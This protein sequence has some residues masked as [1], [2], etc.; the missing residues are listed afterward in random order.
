VFLLDMVPDD[1]VA[2]GESANDI[3]MPTLVPS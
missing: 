1:A 2:I 3:E